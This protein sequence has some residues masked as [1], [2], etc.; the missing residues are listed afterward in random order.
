MRIAVPEYQGRVAPVFDSC[1]RLLIFNRR[2][3][4]QAL[5]GQEDWSTVMPMARALRLKQMDVRVL[6]CG[7]ISCQM[8]D[9]IKQ[10]GIQVIPWLAGEIPTILRAFGDGTILE[11]QFAMPGTQMCR[12]QRQTR[13]R[14][15]CQK[16]TRISETGKE[17]I[18]C[19]D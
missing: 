18:S 9:L 13:R 4:G 1:R 12:K 17:N 14:G 7:A 2:H 15:C 6:L 19:Q 10:Q 5:V 11:P 16:E 8:E 3:G